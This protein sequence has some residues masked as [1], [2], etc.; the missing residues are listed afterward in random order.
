MNTNFVIVS[1]CLTM[2]ESSQGLDW[3]IVEKFRKK[4]EECYTTGVNHLLSFISVII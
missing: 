4:G 3:F 2:S 1:H